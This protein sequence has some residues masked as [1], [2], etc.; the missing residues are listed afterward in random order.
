MN[1]LLVEDYEEKA[2]NIIAFLKVEFPAYQVERC[3]SYNSAQETIFEGSGKYDLILLDM[4]MTTYDLNADTSGG[5]P[6]PTAGNDILEGMYLRNITTPVIVV[7]MYNV[8]GRKELAAFHEELLMNYPQN[9]KS[10]VFYSSQ[11][12]DWKKELKKCIKEVLQ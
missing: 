7:T 8:F 3:T 6:E 10:Y 2:N 5:K 4:S 9:Y 1:I 11:R 12:N